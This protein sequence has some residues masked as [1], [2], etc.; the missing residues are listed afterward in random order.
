MFVTDFPVMWYAYLAVWLSFWAALPPWKKEIKEAIQF[1]LMGTCLGVVV[2]VLAI[3]M[4]LWEYAG[5]NWP[6][7][8]WPAYFVA[9]IVWHQ[10]FRFFDAYRKK[11]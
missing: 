11:A 2:E 9:S 10:L 7:V 3:A 4:G 6:V 8:L 5:G 1:G